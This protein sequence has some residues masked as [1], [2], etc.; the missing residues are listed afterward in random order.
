MMNKIGRKRRKEHRSRATAYEAL[1]GKLLRYQYSQ[2]AEREIIRREINVL[3]EK[4][5]LQRN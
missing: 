4:L 1:K 2:G 3:A 5:Q